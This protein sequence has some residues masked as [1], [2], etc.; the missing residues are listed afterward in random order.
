ML[1]A[2]LIVPRSSIAEL[3]FPDPAKKNTSVTPS[4]RRTA[5]VAGRTTELDGLTHVLVLALKVPSLST[6]KCA[7]RTWPSARDPPPQASVVVRRSDIDQLP[8]A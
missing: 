7:V 2:E 1:P 4:V 8:V 6:S 3:E 5:P